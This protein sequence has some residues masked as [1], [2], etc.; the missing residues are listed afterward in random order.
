MMH[1][2]GS[3]QIDV[4]RIILHP[5]Q[6][7]GH[8][9]LCIIPP[10]QNSQPHVLPPYYALYHHIKTLRILVISVVNESETEIENLAFDQASSSVSASASIP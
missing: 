1:V 3:Q 10:Y 2:K 8:T 5:T 9:G 7:L 4:M 6:L